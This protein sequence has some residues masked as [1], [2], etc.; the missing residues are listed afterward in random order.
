MTRLLT[1]TALLA[2]VVAFAAESPAQP[3]KGGGY[4][5]KPTQEQVAFFEKK[6]R[7]V[8]VEQCYKCHSAEAE[9]IKGGLTLDTRDGTRKGGDTGPIIVPGNPDRSKLIARCS[10][11]NPDTAMPPKGKLSD[12]VVA[13]FEAWVKMG[14]PDPRDGKA[15][16]APEVR[17]RPREG[18]RVLGVP[19]AEEGP[20]AG[21]E[22]RRVG[23]SPTD[24]RVPPRRNSTRRG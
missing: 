12:S 8:L 3:T 20:R 6:I 10:H 22:E 18:P 14:A 19:A 7:P 2:G 15:A 21:G 1:A 24:R 16:A 4:A 23:R 5:D 11:K 13:D 17:D 9:K